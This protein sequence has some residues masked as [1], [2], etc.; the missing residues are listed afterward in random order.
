MG[1]GILKWRRLSDLFTSI[2][3]FVMHSTTG[4]N[5]VL[6]LTCDAPGRWVLLLLGRGQVMLNTR[7]VDLERRI[8]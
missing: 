4:S 7:T 2:G 1:T 6:S 3:E 8:I 5:T